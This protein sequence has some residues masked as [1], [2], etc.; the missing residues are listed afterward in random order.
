[1]RRDFSDGG[2]VDNRILV[3]ERRYKPVEGVEVGDAVDFDVGREGG[4]GGGAGEDLD[5]AGESGVGVEGGEDGGTEVAG[6]L[7][8][9]LGVVIEEEISVVYPDDDD[10]FEN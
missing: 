6:G 10:V 8:G 1:M 9:G 7:K 4:F 5:V 2:H 3:F